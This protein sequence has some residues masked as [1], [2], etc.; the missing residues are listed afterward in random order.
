MLSFLF[1]L[2]FTLLLVT[3][4]SQ[5]VELKHLAQSQESPVD[6]LAAQLESVHGRGRV[7]NVGTG[8]VSRGGQ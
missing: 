4:G 8:R 7:T 2:L 5:A 1:S 6:T 3:S